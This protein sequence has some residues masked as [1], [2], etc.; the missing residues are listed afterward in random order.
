MGE[1]HGRPTPDR[2]NPPPEDVRR[3]RPR[4]EV[5]NTPGPR[6]A[7][8]PA[9]VLVNPRAPRDRPASAKRDAPDGPTHRP[10]V[11]I[12]PRGEDLAEKDAPGASR[13]DRARKRAFDQ[14]NLANVD[15]AFHEWGETWDGV[16]TRPPGPTHAQADVR[17]HPTMF[18]TPSHGVDSGNTLT[19][20]LVT[21]ILLG[22]GLRW[23]YRKASEL[24]ETWNA[25]NR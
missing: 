13:V 1:L 23:S 24:K 11:L 15:S 2:P 25:R 6:P 3:P 20:M 5:R 17:Q 10:P 18:E 19:A 16:R 22:E 7:P 4:I 12:P 8:G 14:D 9:D 21:G